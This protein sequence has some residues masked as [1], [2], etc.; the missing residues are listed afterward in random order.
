MNG[1]V[2][3]LHKAIT[4]VTFNYYF[5]CKRKMW[6]F[7]NNIQMEDNSEDVKMG[8]LIDENSYTR[9]DKQIN[10]DNVVNI[11]FIKGKKVLHEVKKSSKLE[12]SAIYQVKYYLYYLQQK[13]ADVQRGIIDYPLLRERVEVVL[14]DEDKQEIEDILQKIKAICIGIVVPEPLKDKKRCKKCAYFD[15]CFI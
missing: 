12:E 9:E 8:K 11:D 10:I 6:Y 13:G 7:Y 3:T 15:L 14:T 2:M 1:Q 5:V 4:G